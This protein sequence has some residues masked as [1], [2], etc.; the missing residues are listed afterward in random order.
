MTYL[1]WG[2]DLPTVALKANV[3]PQFQDGITALKF[4]YIFAALFSFPLGALPAFES[5]VAVVFGAP[6]QVP[7]L[8]APE[9]AELP[10]GSEIRTTM[11]APESRSLYFKKIAFRTFFTT[12]AVQA[13]FGLN[14]VVKQMLSILGAVC[15]IPLAL[16][17]PG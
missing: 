8:T 17:L 7:V 5:F 2:D 4:L 12:A 3:P 14:S 16:I 6:A 9:G 11:P 1:A 10:P 15:C 13:G